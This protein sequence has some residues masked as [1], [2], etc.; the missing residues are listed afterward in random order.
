MSRRHRRHLGLGFSHLFLQRFIV[1][2]RGEFCLRGFQGFI[3]FR[4]IIGRFDQSLVRRHLSIDRPLRR[5]LSRRQRFHGDGIVDPRFGD[6][7][8]R[9]GPR[10]SIFGRREDQYSTR[11]CGPKT[12]VAAGDSRR[13]ALGRN[14][15]RTD[16]AIAPEGHHVDREMIASTQV[17]SR[18]RR[19]TGSRRREGR[20]N[21]GHSKIGG[22][23]ADDESVLKAR[24]AAR[25]AVTIA[26]R[27]A[28]AA[29]GRCHK[30]HGRVVVDSVEQIGQR[31][32][33]IVVEGTDPR[34]DFLTLLVLFHLVQHND[35]VGCGAGSMSD[36][37]DP[38]RV[39]RLGLER[40]AID[41]TARSELSGDL[42][43]HRDRLRLRAQVVGFDFED[44]GR[45]AQI[46]HQRVGRS[47][48]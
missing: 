28:I 29:V 45:F 5:R 30:L 10:R 48:R 35:G 8:D 20:R 36:D 31:I 39:L 43:R 21:R 44:R 17:D 26:Q 27:E 34:Q 2:L 9:P 25:A 22:L 16:K 7:L 37:L 32:G 24:V 38:E 33:G 41:I 23:P 11:W 15:D 14:R 6:Q 12:D 40:E 47:H 19:Q 18:R 3:G 4:Q 1:G 46:D 42:P 13:Q